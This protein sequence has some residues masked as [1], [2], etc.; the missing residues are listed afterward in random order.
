MA[1]AGMSMNE[2]E[3]YAR[4]SKVSIHKVR[5]HP[6]MEI[7]SVEIGSIMPPTHNVGQCLFSSGC[8]YHFKPVLWGVLSVRISPAPVITAVVFVIRILRVQVTAA[9]KERTLAR[10]MC[11]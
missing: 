10:E 11:L 1:C 3:G 9:S 6:K 2:I 5:H 7:P 4:M 8:C